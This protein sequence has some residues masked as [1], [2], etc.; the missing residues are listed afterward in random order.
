MKQGGKFCLLKILHPVTCRGQ[1]TCM[2]YTRDRACVEESLD[3]DNNGQPERKITLA[4]VNLLT[5]SCMT[6]PSAACLTRGCPYMICRSD[7]YLTILLCDGPFR[8]LPMPLVTLGTSGYQ[9]LPLQGRYRLSPYHKG[10]GPLFKGVP[11]R[12]EQSLYQNVY[13]GYTKIL[14]L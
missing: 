7:A 5:R 6:N 14:I 11:W 13:P 9:H 4:E 8:G 1:T 10:D 3:T 2:L 12:Y